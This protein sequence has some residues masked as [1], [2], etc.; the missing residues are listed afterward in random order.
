MTSRANQSSVPS[1][2]ATSAEGRAAANWA[3]AASPRLLSNEE[4]I[5][6]CRSRHDRT[7]LARAVEGLMLPEQGR[8][9]KDQILAMPCGDTD[10]CQPVP[11]GCIS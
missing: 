3:Q 11:L 9:S 7:L 8:I 6:T 2:W 4:L 5:T 10:W 1:P